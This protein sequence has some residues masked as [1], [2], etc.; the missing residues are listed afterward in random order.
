[1]SA[2]PELELVADACVD[3]VSVMTHAPVPEAIV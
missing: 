3:P 2:E 1:M